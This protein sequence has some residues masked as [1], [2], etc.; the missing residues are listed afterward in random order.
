ALGAGE[1]ERELPGGCSAE[2]RRGTPRAGGRGEGGVG[3]GRSQSDRAA[4]AGRGSAARALRARAEGRSAQCSC[5]SGEEGDLANLG[6]A[7][8]LA[9]VEQREKQ[10]SAAKRAEKRYARIG[11]ALLLVFLAGTLLFA[12][13]VRAPWLS[14][15]GPSG[16][17]FSQTAPNATP[18]PPY[19][20]WGDL[21]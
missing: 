10:L 2:A 16:P 8:E 20:K 6:G 7:N 13:G 17:S 15:T 21:N 11:V 4:R 1:S 12:T 5:C 18:A 19:T 14:E 3:Q 9:E